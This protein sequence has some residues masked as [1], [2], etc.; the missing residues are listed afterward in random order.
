[1]RNDVEYVYQFLTWTLDPVG[2]AVSLMIVLVALARIDLRTTVAVVLPVFVVVGLVRLATRRVQAYRRAN[3]AALG[4]VTGFLGEVFGAPLAIKVSGAERHVVAHL[5]ALNEARRRA[6]LFDLV[7]T[8]TLRS[9][10]GNAASL[11]TGVLLL[12]AA[13]SIRAGRLTVGDFA[14]IVS[15]LG[16][17]AGATGAFGDFLGR[18]R[19]AEVSFERLHALLPGAAPDTLVRPAPVYPDELA[20]REDHATP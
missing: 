2:Q 1:F 8:Q 6:A 18:L 10:G 3:Q 13:G 5:R 17:L 16:M 11:G 7:F 4:E 19:Q 9:I 15:Y 20:A 14:L 12:L